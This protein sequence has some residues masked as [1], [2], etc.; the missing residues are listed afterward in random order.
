MNK[1]KHALESFNLTI[2]ENVLW[3]HYQIDNSVPFLAEG[4]AQ[5][6]KEI[7]D[8]RKFSRNR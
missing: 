3:I 2:L 7:V 8:E 6:I 5:T 1:L 4:V